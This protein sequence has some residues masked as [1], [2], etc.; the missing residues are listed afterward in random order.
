MKYQADKKY[1]DVRIEKEN[2]YYANLLLEDYAGNYSEL[3]AITQYVYQNFNSFQKYPKFAEAM[4][5]IAIVE[6]RHLELLGKTIH[7]LGLNPEYK[8]KVNMCDYYKYW[9][10]SNINYDTY[11]IYMLNTNIIQEE[12]AIKNYKYHLN[13]IK[14]KYIQ[15]LLK[16]IIEDEVI[17]I[18]CFKNLLQEYVK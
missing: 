11:I 8:S 4:S 18:E 14:D 5:R 9:D 15:E 17:H 3:T 2:K 13:I 7:L 10:S 16:R 6:M 12:I 1:P